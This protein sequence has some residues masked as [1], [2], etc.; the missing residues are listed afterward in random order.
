VAG[1]KRRGGSPAVVNRNAG[2]LSSEMGWRKGGGGGG[3]GGGGPPARGGGGGGGV[4]LHPN[5]P[6]PPP[7]I[8]SDG[9][10][11]LTP[12]PTKRVKG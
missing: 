4:T 3:G 1:L 11:G 6:L 8:L 10:L 2:N 9:G 12:Y 5:P 7:V